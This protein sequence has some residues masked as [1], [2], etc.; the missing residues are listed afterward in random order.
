MNSTGQLCGLA[1]GSINNDFEIIIEHAAH[2][3]DDD[4]DDDDEQIE[5]ITDEGITNIGENHNQD[6]PNLHITFEQQYENMIK[7]QVGTLLME[8]I[9][10]KKRK[11]T[12]KT[13]KLTQPDSLIF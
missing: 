4:D 2:E 10:W 9:E 8:Y 1:G 3:N 12:Q 5:N 7:E 13:L 6:Y 11:T